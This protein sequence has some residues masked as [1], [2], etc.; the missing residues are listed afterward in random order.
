MLAEYYSEV[1]MKKTLVVLALLF[2]TIVPSYADTNTNTNANAKAQAE[3]HNTES[4]DITKIGF[5]K[6]LDIAPQVQMKEMFKNYQKYLNSKD[7]DKFLGVYDESYK[8]SDGYGKDKL[9]VLAEAVVKNYP[10]MKY[11]IKVV[12]IDV[13][14]DNATVITREKMYATLDSNIQYIKGKGNIDAESTN[15]YYLR[16]FSNEWRITSDFI[17]N[18]KTAIR[19]GLAKYV[20]MLLDAPSTVSPGQD[21]TAVLKMNLPD[22]YKALIAIDSEPISY[23]AEKLPETFR[24]LKPSGIQ[25]RILYSNKENKN[26]NAIASI[27]IVKADIKDDNINVNIVGLAFLSSRVNVLEQ[28]KDDFVINSS[29]PKAE[30]NKTPESKNK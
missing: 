16:R 22:K 26:E 2:S 7:I 15:I 12:S 17:I 3:T 29:E 4:I 18:E 6:R 13:N 21:Y 10:D 28:K 20:P 24:G 30:Q 11:D 5:H 9:K 1:K 27:G 14:V 8:S 23:P 25:E 19:Y